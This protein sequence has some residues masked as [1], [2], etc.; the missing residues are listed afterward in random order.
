MIPVDL[1][2]R[3]WLWNCLDRDTS[4]FLRTRRAAPVL[5]KQPLVDD[6]ILRNE[7]FEVVINEQTGGIAHI[8]A[9]DQRTK[10][11]SQQ[12]SFRFPRERIIG[13]GED[14]TKT[15]YA[16][17]RCL[18]RQITSQG[19]L[20]GEV[21]T[22][23]EIIDQ[24]NGE[25]LATFR[26]TIRVWRARPIVELDVTLGDLK[27]PDGDPWNNYFASRFAWNDGTSAVT[28]SVFH[29][30]QGFGSERFETSDYIEAASETERLT[31]VPHGLPFHR[32]T[33][34]RMVDSLLVAA[35]ETRRH[36]RFT[37]AVD[38]TY[39]LE[40]AW[41]A[42]TPV[43][44]IPTEQGPPRTGSSGW[45]FHLDAR[46]VQLTRVLPLSDPPQDALATGDGDAMPLPQGSGFAIRLIE[47]E[48]R[49]KQIRLQ[50][51]RQ[52]IHARKRDNS[53]RTLAEMVLEQ[54]AV[55]IDIGAFEIAEVEL[56]FGKL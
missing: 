45:F 40:A 27:V 53:G 56:R 28:R 13:S 6:G 18:D 16:D 20:R 25:R 19:S 54:D 3:S 37:I 4:G 21:T 48:G 7:W 12:L 41:N 10:R 30:A 31:I 49:S 55:V 8:R 44:V 17:M 23:G 34:P 43:S 15:Q 24:T 29:V 14:A 32:K 50:T 38:A 26:Q 36:F 42:T 22:S 9:H 11:F 46:N 47:T 52:P 39:P 35:G 51:F 2:I 5:P 33:G 1:K